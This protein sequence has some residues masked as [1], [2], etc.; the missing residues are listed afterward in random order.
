MLLTDKILKKIKQYLEAM[1]CSIAAIYCINQMSREASTLCSVGLTEKPEDSALFIDRSR[2]R[3]ATLA[4]DACKYAQKA[5]ASFRQ[6]E[7]DLYKA[8]FL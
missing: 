1:D 6:V 3:V 8:S 5:N 4:D 2:A 7:Q